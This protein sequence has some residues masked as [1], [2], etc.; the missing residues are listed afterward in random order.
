MA[1]SAGQL[2][3]C[4]CIRHK[5]VH[6]KDKQLKTI[7]T[8]F[9][10]MF[11]CLQRLACRLLGF[12]IR[13]TSHLELAGLGSEIHSGD[14]RR[15]GSRLHVQHGLHDLCAAQHWHV[16]PTRCPNSPYPLLHHT[17]HKLEFVPHIHSLIHLMYLLE[18]SVIVPDQHLLVSMHEN[19]TMSSYA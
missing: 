4:N 9:T 11:I 19:Y 12:L 14:L 5:Q 10:S 6:S 2:S 15:D 13:D 7:S 16:T 17:C 3:S 1:F 8:V 18:F